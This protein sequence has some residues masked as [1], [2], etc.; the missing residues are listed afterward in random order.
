MNNEKMESPWEA[1]Q[2]SVNYDLSS[3]LCNISFA[4]PQSGLVVAILGPN[5]AGKSTL[6]KA[7]L[8]LI[9]P[10]F[11]SVSFFGKPFSKIR[12]KIAY[13]PQKNHIDWDFPIT[14]LDLV[15]MGSYGKLGLF[16]R[17]SSEQKELALT[18][19]EAVGLSKYVYRQIGQLSGGQQQRL[20]LA[21]ALMQRAEIFLMDEPFAG[22][23]K[24][25]FEVIMKTLHDLKQR[26]K[27]VIVVYHHL[28]DVLEFFDYVL[29]LNKTIVAHG[30]TK[31]IFNQEII[32]LT[33]GRDVSMLDH[34][35]R[36]ARNKF[37]GT[38]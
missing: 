7:S 25:S 37:E 33:Y 29:F 14:V 5:G 21:R 8:S 24:A 13:I 19:L 10:N 6:I 2:L 1:K 38:I 15:L 30:F 4:L 3:V 26:K 23:D 17:I 18:C 9:K 11:G 36:L 22:V 32:R 20:F 35:M 12:E 34:A 28:E 27:T 16:K 31:D